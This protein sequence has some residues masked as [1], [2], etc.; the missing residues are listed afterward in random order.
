MDQRDWDWFMGYNCLGGMPNWG[1]NPGPPITTD[2]KGSFDKWGN[3][4]PIGRAPRTDH[5][6]KVYDDTD[7]ALKT[8]ERSLAKACLY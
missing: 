5:G 1:R 2:G 4:N 3:L 6:G 7:W 8:I